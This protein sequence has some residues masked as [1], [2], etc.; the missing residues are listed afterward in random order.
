MNLVRLK[1]TKVIHRTLLHLYILTMK[2]QKEKLGK[3]SHLLIALKRIKYLVIHLLK[4]TEG[5][6]SENYKMLMKEIKEDTN[7]WKEIPCSW[8]GRVNI[9]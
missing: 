9:I 5:L 4:E 7:S 6:Y 1:D 3:Q 8:I 2:N